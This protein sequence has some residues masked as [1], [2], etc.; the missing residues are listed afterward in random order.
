MAF[1][2]ATNFRID[3]SIFNDAQGNINYYNNHTV[4]GDQ[5][6]NIHG[7]QD[8]RSCVYSA[9]KGYIHTDAF[10]NSNAR[11]EIS[12]CHPDTRK[13]AL[14]TI[15]DWIADPASHLLWLN[16]PVGA[17]K[18][19]IAYTVAEQCRLDGTLG[20]TYFFTKGST[21]G[22]GRGS[23]PLFPTLAY[24]LMLKFPDLVEHLWT[25]IYADRTIFKRSLSLQFDQLVVQP[26]LE[27]AKTSQPTSAVVIIDG[28]D[29]CDGDSIQREIVQLILGLKRQSLSLLFL[30]SS[31][32]EPVIRRAFESSPHPP[33]TCLPLVRS[34]EAD[35]DIRCFLRN[36]FER[37][38]REVEVH[39]PRGASQLPWPSTDA[40][41]MLV[42]KSSG[43]FIYAATVIR[44][45]QE[46]YSNPMNRLDA[47]LKIPSKF[48]SSSAAKDIFA[49]SAA[50]QELD[51]L[52]LHILRKYQN[53][54]ELVNVLRAIMHLDDDA[55]A[56]NIETIFDLRPG[57]VRIM[58]AGLHSIVDIPAGDKP[59]RFLHASFNDFLDDPER[60]REFYV[61]TEYFNAELACIYMRLI[62]AF[63]PSKS[64]GAL[65]LAMR[66]LKA[67]LKA[68]VS[69]LPATLEELINVLTQ[70]SKSTPPCLLYVILDFLLQD[71]LKEF[72]EA[73]A[74]HKCCKT[75]LQQPK[76]QLTEFED[77]II[78]IIRVLGAQTVVGYHPDPPSIEEIGWLISVPNLTGESDV[79]QRTLSL[80]RH[81]LAVDLESRAEPFRQ[82]HNSLCHWLL[83][84]HQPGEWRPRSAH[85]TY[86]SPIPRLLS[87][88]DLAHY[89]DLVYCCLRFVLLEFGQ[90]LS[91]IPPLIRRML[92]CASNLLAVAS[93]HHDRYWPYFNL[94]KVIE[95]IDFPSMLRALPD[96]TT[97]F[98]PR[99]FYL[100]RGLD[101]LQCCLQVNEGFSH[102]YHSSIP[103][104]QEF[105][106]TVYSR[107]LQDPFASRVVPAI[108]AMFT[109]FKLPTKNIEELL[110]LVPGA[111]SC[112]TAMQGLFG[113]G[114]CEGTEELLVPKS[115]R[116][117]LQL[118]R[119]KLRPNQDNNSEHIDNCMDDA[120]NSFL[121]FSCAKHL[122]SCP[123]PG[124]RSCM[125]CRYTLNY[126]SSHL[127]HTKPPRG[128]VGTQMRMGVRLPNAQ[129]VVQW[130]LE[131][132]SFRFL[133]AYLY[134]PDILEL[135]KSPNIPEEFL[136]RWRADWIKPHN[137]ESN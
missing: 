93:S 95:T 56:G 8:I 36:E 115:L 24:Q 55:L 16:G 129:L 32:P 57:S 100:H 108:C 43:H 124:G 50:F 46:D 119:V 97:T 17:G 63:S 38:Y 77:S 96:L 42:D 65:G 113:A 117:L 25:A 91:S 52:Y 85:I 21:S 54:A 136:P 90:P 9:M 107:L 12:R 99:L 110:G 122:A 79:F 103:H 83:V 70:E 73:E 130:L 13:A 66:K 64:G 132:A 19:T 34:L 84:H 72:P 101:G 5:N 41:E 118:G 121:A 120:T 67:C 60:S 2:N 58:L 20:A 106:E 75:I 88:V 89:I 105:L 71:V 87:G 116:A 27:H 39:A 61:N 102:P 92:E 69:L 35:N 49:C 109:G 53:R 40:I 68:T 82:I 78:T 26:L 126:W 47:I 6:I 1:S 3:R 62:I 18:S 76:L 127:Q 45:T 81:D 31:R 7:R 48:T 125:I 37:I 128:L 28:L 44:S 133:F 22:L 111:F 80:S 134:L 23:P 10:H 59:L 86:S 11:C 114:F 112:S 4:Q 123:S 131:A 33:L 30:I 135:Q 74:L 104:Y 29:E 15:S 98:C 51:G 14:K 94:L 137:K